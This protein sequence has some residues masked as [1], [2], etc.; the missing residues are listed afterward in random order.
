M[1][2]FLAH[3]GLTPTAM[4]LS[5][6]GLV[7]SGAV[8]IGFG[9][10]RTGASLSLAGA[11]I[12]GLDGSVARAANRATKRGAFLDAMVDRVG[13]IAVLAGLAVSQR[14][15]IR[16]L[17]LVILS[18]GAALLIP[19]VRAKA[20]AVG[21]DGRGGLMGRAERVILV[22]LGMISGWVEP[23]LWVMVVGT[24]VTVGQRFWVTYRSIDS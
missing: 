1:G 13:E 18:M 3:L 21:M 15:S 14:T 12:D 5:G 20:E 8:L 22:A 10:L 9:Y 2:R 6:F 4:T 23:A 17:L 16:I 11:A 24:W 7:A 19:Y